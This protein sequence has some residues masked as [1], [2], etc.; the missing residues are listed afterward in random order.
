M[1]AV[2]AGRVTVVARSV[3]TDKRQRVYSRDQF[4]VRVVRVRSV[5]VHAPLR[6]LKVGNRM[7]V[8]ALANE[9]SLTPLHFATARNIRCQWKVS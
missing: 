1:Q 8:F 7:P 2:R 6:A 5:Q 4:V 3:G 9:R